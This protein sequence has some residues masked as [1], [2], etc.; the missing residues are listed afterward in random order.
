MLTEND[1]LRISRRIVAGCAPLA[2]GTFGSYATG[3]A[4]EK[5]DLD[6]VVIAKTRGDRAARALAVKRLLF[7]VLHPLDVFVFT[8]EEFEEAAYEELSFVWVI[9][10]QA[11]LYFWAEGA[12]ELIPSLRPKAAPGAFAGVLR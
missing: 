3:A 7:G 5:S 6:L 12:S 8:P 11:R 4:R 2:V 10:K 1:I 9:V